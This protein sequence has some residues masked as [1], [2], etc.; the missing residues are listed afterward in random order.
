MKIKVSATGQKSVSVT[1]IPLY[2]YAGNSVAKV[3][4]TQDGD[5]TLPAPKLGNDAQSVVLVAFSNLAYAMTFM[6]NSVNGYGNYPGCTIQAPL[7]ANNT[8]II[9]GHIT[10]KQLTI[11]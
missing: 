3:T 11:C 1:E 10:I 2:D 4:L 6:S 9:C 7:N 8:F 5:P